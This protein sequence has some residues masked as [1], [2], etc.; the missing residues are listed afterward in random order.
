MELTSKGDNYGTVIEEPVADFHDLAAAGL[1]NA[2]IDTVAWLCT[3]RR[4]LADATAA[5]PHNSMVIVV[6]A[7]KDKIVYKI[8]FDLPDAGLEPE[9]TPNNIQPIP[10]ADT[11]K[12]DAMEDK[13]RQLIA[14]CTRSQAPR[15][16]F[17]QL[18]E[19]QMHRSVLDTQKCIGG[20]AICR[21]D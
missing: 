2:G 15:M 16:R 1:D 18:G 4:D 5:A 9:I 14:H 7:N 8:T 10:P 17:L 3:A 12:I 11:N 19:V 20:K 6:E 21:N 13:P